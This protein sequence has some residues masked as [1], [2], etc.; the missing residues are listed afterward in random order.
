MVTFVSIYCIFFSV[1]FKGVHNLLQ[2]ETYA[3]SVYKLDSNKKAI[4]IFAVLL[5]K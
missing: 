5:P 3:M 4:E 2:N 1:F